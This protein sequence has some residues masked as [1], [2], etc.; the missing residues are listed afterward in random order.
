MNMKHF[1]ERG[2]LLCAYPYF[3]HFP[4]LGP[5]V[6]LCALILSWVGVISQLDCCGL[7]QNRVRLFT[8]I[9]YLTVP[10]MVHGTQCC[11]ADTSL[12]ALSQTC[13]VCS[14]WGWSVVLAESQ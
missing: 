2:W 8:S 1:L 14:P 10:S 7:L 13:L 3:H 12:I 4:S 5:T 11:P 9:M 6:T